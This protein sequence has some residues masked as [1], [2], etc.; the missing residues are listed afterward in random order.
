MGGHQSLISSVFEGRDPFDDPFFTRPF[1]SPFGGPF[2]SMFEPGVFGGNGNPFVGAPP[3]GFIEQQEPQPNKRRGPVI[4]ELDS[5]DERADDGGATKMN[6]NP[7]KH[8]RLSKE[9]YIEIPDDDAEGML[10]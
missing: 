3:S 8:S 5:D 6:D 1:G 10:D 9:P 7:R 2:G 4:Q